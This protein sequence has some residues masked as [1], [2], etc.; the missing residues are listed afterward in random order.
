MKASLT[1]NKIRMR[2][3]RGVSQVLGSLFMLAIVAGIG[4]VLLFQGMNSINS[5]NSSM[6]IFD[7][8][9]KDSSRESLTITHVRFH[10][11][12]DVTIWVRNT[13]GIDVVVDSVTM[14]KIAAQTLILNE[15]FSSSTP[16]Q[17]AVKEV[18]KITRGTSLSGS[19]NPVDKFRITV[20]TVR[21][22]SFDIVAQPF[23]T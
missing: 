22:S 11:N 20:T 7:I 14:I 5:F 2:K 9:T 8:E 21:G 10:D 15:D 18:T 1:R 19:W 16:P 23:N 12:D 13:G 6:A 4:S 3:R 17:V